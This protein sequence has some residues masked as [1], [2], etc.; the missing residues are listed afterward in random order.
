MN[1]RQ[2]LTVGSMIKATSRIG[3]VVRGRKAEGEG[4]RM[5]AVNNVHPSSCTC[6][7]CFKEKEKA[8]KAAAEERARCVR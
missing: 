2:P 3:S 5:R 4:D 1:E 7:S 6:H 8:K